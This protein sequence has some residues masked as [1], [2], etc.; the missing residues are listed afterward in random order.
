MKELLRKLKQERSQHIKAKGLYATKLKEFSE[1]NSDLIDT[2]SLKV[3]NITEIESEIKELAIKEY[4]KTGNKKLECGVGIRVRSRF[5][6]EEEAALHWAQN[7][8]LALKLDK[9]AFESIAKTQALLFVEQ[10]E[11]PTATIPM[12]IELRD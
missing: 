2:I 10:R 9:K 6:Y 11:I 12:K 8:N 7:H 3:D 1:N 5:I 4:T